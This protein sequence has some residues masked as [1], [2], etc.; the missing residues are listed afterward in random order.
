[1]ILWMEVLSIAEKHPSFCLRRAERRKLSR[2]QHSFPSDFEL[3]LD[4]ESIPVASC[5]AREPDLYL[6]VALVFIT[7][8]F[9]KF[10]PL[11]L[12]KQ[13]CKIDW[14]RFECIYKENIFYWL[15]NSFVAKSMLLKGWWQTINKTLR[16]TITWKWVSTVNQCHYI[17]QNHLEKY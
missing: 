8:T 13:K 7:L 16:R 6:S 17:K 4:H 5:P 9:R 15:I 1:M 14:E 3:N 11:S 2:A 10:S 12:G